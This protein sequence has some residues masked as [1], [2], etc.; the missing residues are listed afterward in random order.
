CCRKRKKR[1]GKRIGRSSRRLLPKILNRKSSFQ[2]NGRSS[3]ARRRRG[4]G[5]RKSRSGESSKGIGAAAKPSWR[6]CPIFQAVAARERNGG[7]RQGNGA[8]PKSLIPFMWK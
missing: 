5:C 7:R 1:S 8:D 3:F 6:C 4:L 2:P